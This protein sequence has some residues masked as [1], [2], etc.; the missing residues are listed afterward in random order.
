LPS[1]R[2]MYATSCARP[3]SHANFRLSH[4]KVS[5]AHH[6]HS[7]SPAYAGSASTRSSKSTIALH[8]HPSSP[9]SK[10]K[11][12]A[13]LPPTSQPSQQSCAKRSCATKI[14][15]KLSNISKTSLT[16]PPVHPPLQPPH[17]LQLPPLPR[18]P[19]HHVRLAQNPLRSALRM[20][21][22]PL[23]RSPLKHPSAPRERESF[24]LHEQAAQER[25]DALPFF[26]Q[27]GHGA[28]AKVHRIGEEA[29]QSALGG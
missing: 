5:I 22:P 23:L 20:D 25:Y 28:Q 2:Q 21:P 4:D 16:T 14:P 24:L 9:K 3:L 29:L 11:K 13:C 17:L 1:A 19:L 10:P 6:S 26:R 12:S 27:S 15:P 7:H 18:S 8:I